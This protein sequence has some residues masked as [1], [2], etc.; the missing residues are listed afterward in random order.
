MKTRIH[1]G[2]PSAVSMTIPL[3]I[4]LMEYARED[5]KSD[6]DLHTLAERMLEAD[7]VLSMSDYG[8]LVGEAS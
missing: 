4:R 2:D 8:R 1:V 7:D 5:A 6:I 3:M